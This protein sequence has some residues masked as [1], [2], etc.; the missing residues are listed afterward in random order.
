[1][2]RLNFKDGRGDEYTYVRYSTD[3]IKITKKKAHSPGYH[4][5]EFSEEAIERL[6]GFLV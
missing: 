4:E 1:M 5:I 3:E 2:N 6:K